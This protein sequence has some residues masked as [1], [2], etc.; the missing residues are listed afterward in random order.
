V[1]LFIGSGCAS[2]FVL[3]VRSLSKIWTKQ[4]RRHDS[5]KYNFCVAR[6]WESKSVEE[7]QAQALS[8][9]SPAKPPLTPGQLANQRQRQSLLLS[10]QH[11]LQQLQAAQNPRHRE[12]LQT[13]L[14]DLD[15]QLARMA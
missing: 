9:P 3:P 4:R 10:R 12:L 15:A 7:Q 14:A 13:A 1:L 11:V 2:S 5:H 6:G 8:T